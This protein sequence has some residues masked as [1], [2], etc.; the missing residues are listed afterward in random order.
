VVYR[1]GRPDIMK[2]SSREFLTTAK[3]ASRR[4]QIEWTEGN[5]LTPYVERSNVAVHLQ[6]NV[7]YS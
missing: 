3:I 4:K 1:A 5:R 6:V 2:K 7:H